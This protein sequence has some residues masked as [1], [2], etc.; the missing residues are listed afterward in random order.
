[1]KKALNM[2]FLKLQQSMINV[3]FLNVCAFFLDTCS[4]KISN[5]E[6]K[7]EKKDLIFM[8]INII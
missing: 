8:K 3:K 5:S 7:I 4:S 1:M 2:S 6:K